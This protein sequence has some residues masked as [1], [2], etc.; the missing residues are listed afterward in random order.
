MLIEVD[1]G[2][3]LELEASWAQK[4][5]YR[6]RTERAQLPAASLCRLKIERSIAMTYRAIAARLLGSSDRK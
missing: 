3:V 2:A 6:S 1:A 5:D 4:R